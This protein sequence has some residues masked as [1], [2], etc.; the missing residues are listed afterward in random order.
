M[1][2]TVFIVMLALVTLHFSFAFGQIITNED[3]EKKY[4]KS[5]QTQDNEVTAAEINKRREENSKAL[6]SLN[7]TQIKSS[8]GRNAYI[9]ACGTDEEKQALADK[10]DRDREKRAER[11]R[12]YQDSERD[13]KIDEM[14]RKMTYGF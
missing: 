9:D 7:C 11:K 1:K 8:Y 10:R 12:S 4:G 14:H 5:E 13:R 3:L 6:D 2:K